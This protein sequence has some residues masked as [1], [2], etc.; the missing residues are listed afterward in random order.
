M[1]IYKDINKYHMKINK[2]RRKKMMPAVAQ[3]LRKAVEVI[4]RTVLIRH[5]SGPRMPRG[6]GSDMNATLARV[7][8]DLAGSVKTDV[9]MERNDIRAFVMAGGGAAR[10][11]ARAHEYGAPSRNLPRRPYIG[12]AVEV[13]RRNTL[14][15]IMKALGRSYRRTHG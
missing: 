12:P 14:K 7:T 4:R 9:K 3:A 13:K 5:L 11:Y 15:L 2:W 6:V 8:G 10:A 1:A